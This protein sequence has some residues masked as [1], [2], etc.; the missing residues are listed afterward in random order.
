MGTKTND[1][2]GEA[3]NHSYQRSTNRL[4]ASLGTHLK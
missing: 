2:F 1:L 4:E 3:F